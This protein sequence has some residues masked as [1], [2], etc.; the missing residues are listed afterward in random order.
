MVYKKRARSNLKILSRQ[1]ATNFVPITAVC[2]DLPGDLASKT[3]S[4]PKLRVLQRMPR[5]DGGYCLHR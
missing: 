1:N 4:L 5:S 2:S 3:R